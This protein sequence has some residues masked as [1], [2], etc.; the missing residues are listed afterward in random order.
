[1]RLGCPADAAGGHAW[2]EAR[3]GRVTTRKASQRAPLRRLAPCVGETEAAA[4]VERVREG[5]RDDYT[6]PY[7][8]SEDGEVREA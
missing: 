6:R 5:E 2:R 3:A 7:H 1:M 4:R 8:A